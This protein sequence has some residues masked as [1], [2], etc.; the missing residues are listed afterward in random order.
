MPPIAKKSALHNRLMGEPEIKESFK[1]LGKSLEELRKLQG[2]ERHKKMESLEASVKSQ[3][4][5][6]RMLK[7]VIEEL[8]GKGV[9]SPAKAAEPT[10]KNRGENSLAA[11][12]QK[13]DSLRKN[14]YGTLM[15]SWASSAILLP[16]SELRKR[17]RKLSSHGAE[18]KLKELYE[19]LAEMPDS[20]KKNLGKKYG[21]GKHRNILWTGLF[22][23]LPDKGPKF[24]REERNRI[25]NSTEVKSDF[26]ARDIDRG[27]LKKNFVKREE[28]LKKVLAKIH[29]KEREIE[30]LKAK[31]TA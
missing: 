22:K 5:E 28:G 18:G 17:A 2:K 30:K 23:I 1:N 16:R 6:I 8:K 4:E 15:R 25:F 14:E 7:K 9:V 24:F 19:K 29:E 27:E 10:Q 20:E 26:K 12:G 21:Y 31:K 3:S 13:L 11:A